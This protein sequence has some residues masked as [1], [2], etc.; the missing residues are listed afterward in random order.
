[1]NS[2]KSDRAYYYYNLKALQDCLINPIKSTLKE[3]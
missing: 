2:V 3:V 1:M